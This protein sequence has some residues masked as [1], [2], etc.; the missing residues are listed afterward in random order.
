MDSWEQ[1]VMTRLDKKARK[2]R[3]R[4]EK[5]EAKTRVDQNCMDVVHPRRWSPIINRVPKWLQDI[6]DLKPLDEV[7]EDWIV[8]HWYIRH[9]RSMKSYVPTGVHVFEVTLPSEQGIN[10]F[11]YLGVIS[12]E[13]RPFYWWMEVEVFTLAQRKVL[14]IL[15]QEK[16][17]MATVIDGVYT[18]SGH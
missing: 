2:E 13:T 4:R 14:V 12:K 3:K 17:T 6:L 11:W 9:V 1:G 18:R 7:M 15:D 10:G 8:E 5:L 16:H